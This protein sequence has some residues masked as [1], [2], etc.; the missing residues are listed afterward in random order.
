[1]KLGSKILILTMF[2]AI[3]IFSPRL[4][5]SNNEFIAKQSKVIGHE[6]FLKTRVTVYEM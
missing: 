4:Q 5:P 1:M 2:L 6:L 3:T